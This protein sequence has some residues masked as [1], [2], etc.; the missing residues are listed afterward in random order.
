MSN[1]LK[2][3]VKSIN[4]TEGV[5]LDVQRRFKEQVFNFILIMQDGVG[6]VGFNDESGFPLLKD[7][8]NE[9]NENIVAVKVNKQTLYL[10]T[11]AEEIDNET[12]WFEARDWVDYDIQD[13]F[14]CVKS[15]WEQSKD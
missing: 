7:Y 1:T 3:F 12:G 8:H 11:D 4:S 2:Y 15:V 6:Y 5:L 9:S 13:I 10:C 14:T